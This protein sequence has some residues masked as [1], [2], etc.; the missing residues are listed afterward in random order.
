[1]SKVVLQGDTLTHLLCLIT[2]D[3]VI[4][5]VI[6]EFIILLNKFIIYIYYNIDFMRKERRRSKGYNK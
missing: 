5:Q 3:Y 6:G 4:R 2:L 1:M